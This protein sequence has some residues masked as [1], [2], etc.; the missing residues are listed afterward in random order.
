MALPEKSNSNQEKIIKAATKLFVEQGYQQATISKIAKE[1][2]SSES[3]IYECFD[4]KEDLL[5]T[6]PDVWVKKALGEIKEQL[7]GL[8]GAFN[9]LRKFIWWYL[10]FIEK[11]QLTAQVVFLFLKTNPNFMTTEVYQNV[12]LFYAEL[13]KIF[14]EGKT[15]GEM[16]P[17][18]NPYLARALVLGTIEHLVIRWLLKDR[19]YSLFE[20]LDIIYDILVQGMKHPDQKKA[21]YLF[22]ILR[23][24][25][26]ESSPAGEE[27]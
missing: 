24:E 22:E 6:I 12:K 9:K 18:L 5:L 11:D 26:K 27:K 21:E 2:G 8:V 23:K 15:S 7:Y 19:S 4:G 1:A 3:A 14:E 20:E 16:R 17:D 25:S 13:L 10:R